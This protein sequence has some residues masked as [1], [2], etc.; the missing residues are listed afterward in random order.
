M[1]YTV[2][3]AYDKLYSRVNEV[4]DIFKDF[5]GEDKTDLQGV[6]SIDNFGDILENTFNIKGDGAVI[7]ESKM[8]EIKDFFKNQHALIYIWW[9]DV[10]VTNENDKFIDIEDLYAEVKITL[11]GTIPYEYHGFRLDKSTYTETQYF[12]GY[13]HSH[14][15]SFAPPRLHGFQA[16]C[17]GRGPINGTIAELRNNYSEVTWMLFCQE[18]S[19]YVTVE[20]LTGVPYFRLENVK[21]GS[22]THYFT[23]DS[24]FR[25]FDVDNLRICDSNIVV[26]GKQMIKTFVEYYLR[27][28][29]LRFD[30]D[31]NKYRL[32]M[33]VYDFIMDISNC[34]IK[35]FN[36]NGS[37]DIKKIL[38][39]K[40]FLKNV[41]VLN[42]RFYTINGRDGYDID[43]IPETRILTF[44]GRDIFLKVKRE[45]GMEE[46]NTTII[47]GTCA[48]TIL[49]KIL[50]I[51]NYH[52]GN[53]EPNSS[54][55]AT[56]KTVYYL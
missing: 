38:Y 52:Y 9:P 20:S 34:F 14:V 7:S 27:N 41:V 36:E 51:I 13:V 12:C 8:E 24:D 33:S 21:Q 25:S 3:E 11:D 29:N 44:K 43:A 39:L 35:W 6:L 32:G 18:L 15:P 54:S 1:Q 2:Q 42:Q 37:L 48:M 16:P 47:D 56:G 40:N 10:R 22:R 19:L 53:T 31:G 26:D 23:P 30:F 55:T 28:G 45:E 49:N 46:A 17:L 4:Y 50:K 5:F